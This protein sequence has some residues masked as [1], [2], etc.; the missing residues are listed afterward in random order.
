MGGGTSSVTA[1]IQHFLWVRYW[2]STVV[3]KVVSSARAHVLKAWFL[4]GI[5]TFGRWDLAEVIRAH[6]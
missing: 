5:G 1:N 4:L 2:H 3:E 6:P